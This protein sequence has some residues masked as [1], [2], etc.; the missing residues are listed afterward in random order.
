[1]SCS[2]NWDNSVELR[3]EHEVDNEHAAFIYQATV[4]FYMNNG[5]K[6]TNRAS[7]FTLENKELDGSQT[8]VASKRD[9]PSGKWYRE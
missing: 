9:S 8:F 3:E 1:M 4:T 2:R 5:D 7:F 6:V